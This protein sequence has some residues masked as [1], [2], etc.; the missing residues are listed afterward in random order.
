MGPPGNWCRLPASVCVFQETCGLSLVLE[1]N[2]D[3]YACDHF[4][5]PGYRLGNI[6]ETPLIKLV[7]SSRQ[8]RFG[9]DKRDRLSGY[10]RACD[11]FFA[12]QG[13]CPR[14]RF[15]KTPPGNEEGLNYLCAGYRLFFH[16]IDQSMRVMAELLGRGRPAA[17]IIY[18]KDLGTVRAKIR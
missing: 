18:R 14:N 2:G 16:H 3:L 7:T 8:Q 5:E 11:V 12:C 15:L 6:L 13:E 9:S 4:V 1:H 17:E 10:C